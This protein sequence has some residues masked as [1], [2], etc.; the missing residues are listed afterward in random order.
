MRAATSAPHLRYAGQTAPPRARP[1]AS[2]SDTADCPP[3]TFSRASVASLAALMELTEEH[4]SAA[5][6]SIAVSSIVVTGAE[7]TLRATR[8]DHRQTFASTP[9]SAWQEIRRLVDPMDVFE[10]QNDLASNATSLDTAKRSRSTR[11]VSSNATA[12]IC[13]PLPAP[14]S[15]CRHLRRDGPYTTSANALDS[16]APS[17]VESASARAWALRHRD[18][19][20]PLRPELP[21]ASTRGR[22]APFHA[23]EKSPT[24]TR[25]ES[26]ASG[27]EQRIRSERAPPSRPRSDACVAEIMS[28]CSGGRTRWNRRRSSPRGGMRL[29]VMIAC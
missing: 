4:C 18:G 25:R 8:Q 26:R 5:S 28:R 1:R 9:I 22:P 29:T 10:Y 19:A 3:P 11:K 27:V 24:F 20:V 23:I 13:T 21:L 6:A 15:R 17:S 7:T 12:H 14:S 2:R 16:H